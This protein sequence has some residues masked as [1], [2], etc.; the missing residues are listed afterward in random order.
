VAE[1]TAPELKATLGAT[2]VEIGFADVVSAERA[3][4]TLDPVGSSSMLPDGRTVRVNVTDG[5][6]GVLDIARI[7]DREAL[8]PRDFTVREPT[9]DDVFLSLTGHPVEPDAPL[10]GEIPVRSAVG[11]SDS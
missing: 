7:T 5:A 6:R 4:T 11:G 9:L 10:D 8:V 2:I 3:L 1:G